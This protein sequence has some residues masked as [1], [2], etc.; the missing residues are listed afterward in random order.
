MRLPNQTRLT[1]NNFSWLIDGINSNVLR[2]SL[3]ELN[4]LTHKVSYKHITTNI[5]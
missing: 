5:A 3:P 1:G 2:I 4:H